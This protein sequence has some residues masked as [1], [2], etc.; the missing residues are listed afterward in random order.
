MRAGQIHLTLKFLGEVEGARAEA[1]ALQLPDAL[2]ATPVLALELVG[3]GA[4][5]S[6]ERPRVLW[7]GVH[8]PDGNL[9]ELQE[10]IEERM[11][12]LGFTREPRAFS[13]HLT[14]GR[15]REGARVIDLRALRD[16]L[17]AA[18][19]ETTLRFEVARVTLFRSQLTPDGAIYSSLAEFPLEAAT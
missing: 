18:A 11:V 14:L 15:A 4:F 12:G 2:R 13:P 10:R 17:M 5:P 19:P 8:L 9:V 16:A 7:A 3:N 6:L 1:I